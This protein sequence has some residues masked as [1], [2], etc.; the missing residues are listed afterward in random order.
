[1]KK[2]HWFTDTDA[3]ATPDKQ[4]HIRNKEVISQICK[5]LKLKTGEKIVVRTYG[6]TFEGIITQALQDKVILSDIQEVEPLYTP[7]KLSLFF[8]IPKK[9]KFELILE[10]CTE[11]GVTDF[12]P[13]L[14]DRTIKTS[15]NTARS[16]KIIEEA[17]EQAQRIDTPT[18]HDI[19]NL[20]EVV[21]VFKPT[22]FD[23][24]GGLLSHEQA[25]H[26]HG[27]LIGPEGGFSEKELSHFRNQKLDIYKL[28]GPILKTETAA[29]AA[30]SLIML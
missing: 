6:A 27:I 18:L 29:I 28:K 30:V 7:K 26:I 8:C 16:L 5:V 24:E 14:S 13:V 20:E 21:D 23:V 2:I 15:I 17:S 19:R 1:M 11:L 22:V 12:Y 25:A 3:I 10:K 4:L 9:D